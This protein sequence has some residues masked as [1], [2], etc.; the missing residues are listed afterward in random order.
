MADSSRRPYRQFRFIIEI[1]GVGVA[2]SV[3][4]GFQEVSGLGFDITVA[5]NR[6]GED[7]ENA[8][9]M[10]FAMSKVPN[11][12]FKR[13]VIGEPGFVDWFNAVRSGSQE[14]L[15]SVTVRLQSEDGSVTKSWNLANA[16]PVKYTGPTLSGT[17]NEAAIEEHVMAYERID[18]D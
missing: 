7:V 8:P 18:Q 11:V 6:K 14:Q 15:R 5:E 4:G 16:R 2:S 13:G 10:I 17:D 12:T 3:A 9:H 1:D